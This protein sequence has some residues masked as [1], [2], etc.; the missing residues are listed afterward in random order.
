MFVPQKKSPLSQKHLNTTHL[1][2]HSPPPPCCFV[3]V[4]FQLAAIVAARPVAIPCN[5]G[6]EPFDLRAVQAT[7]IG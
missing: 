1:E 3:A 6:P 7:G 2:S 5:R 4:S